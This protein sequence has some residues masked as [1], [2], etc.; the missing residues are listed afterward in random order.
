ML[1]STASPRVGTVV[2]VL[3]S[4]LVGKAG[5]QL[6][7]C[8]QGWACNAECGNKITVGAEEY[9][10]TTT[11]MSSCSSCS[12]FHVYQEWTSSTGYTNSFLYYSCSTGTWGATM[13]PTGANQFAPTTFPAHRMTLR[14]TSGTQCPVSDSATCAGPAPVVYSSPPP[15]AAI[16]GA[17]DTSSTSDTSGTSGSDA[18][19]PTAG[20]CSDDDAICAPMAPYLPNICSC[21]G[22]NGGTGSFTECSQS[23]SIMGISLG[24]V[25]I[26]VEL[27]P[28]DC[29][30]AYA[31]VSY[32]VGGDW[33]TAGRLAAGETN[34]FPIPGLTIYGGA[35]LYVEV[36]ISGGTSNLVVD[37]HLSLCHNGKCDGDIEGG[38]FGYE[39]GVPGYGQAASTL[40]FPFALITDLKGV[41]FTEQCKC[42]PECTSDSSTG[43]IIGIA[44]AVVVLLI[45][46]AVAGVVIYKKKQTAAA[47]A[48]GKA[49]GGVALTIPSAAPLPVATPVVPMATPVETKV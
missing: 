34:K 36:A 16:T 19:T 26:R 3:L 46:A 28:C 32:Q 25:G 43:M 44:I 23:W 48:G 8:D 38:P 45:A 10:K 24:N 35:G 31:E 15:P 11:A 7:R 40:G 47:A 33:T 2:L 30:G 27:E 1:R 18:T 39:M 5:A 41:D 49:Q 21:S 20:A 13:T 29:G 17:S 14:A 42:A 9:Y 22:T 37:V 4:T 6:T 12:Q